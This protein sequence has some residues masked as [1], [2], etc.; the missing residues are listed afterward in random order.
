MKKYI[1]LIFLSMWIFVPA[2]Q[3][4]RVVDSPY[5]VAVQQSDRLYLTSEPFGYSQKIVLQS[6][7][8][9][10]AH[11]KPE[12]HN[13]FSELQARYADRFSGYILCDVRIASVNVVLSL[14]AILNTIAIPADVE[15]TAINAG[16]TQVLDVRGKDEVWALTNYGTHFSK[17][18]A[19]Y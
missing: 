1:L 15:Q 14:C 16:Y 7:Q 10:L 13:N 8:S 17:K 5:S 6:L 9:M 11:T 18:I 2:Q 3:I 4:S 12:I 19:L